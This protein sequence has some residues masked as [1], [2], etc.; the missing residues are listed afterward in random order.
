MVEQTLARSVYAI[1]ALAGTTTA[2][3]G[4]TS[5]IG[6]A[7]AHQIVAA[8]GKVIVISRSQEKVDSAKTALGESADGIA[9]DAT[10][11]EQVKATFN[12]IAEK[13]KLNHIV[14][15]SGG[16]GPS[17]A[18]L[19]QDQAGLMDIW[20]KKYWCEVLPARYA[21]PHLPKTSDSSI[22]FVTGI[23]NKKIIPG[24]GQK[25]AVNA[26]LEALAKGLAVDLKPIRVNCISPDSLT[27]EPN[28]PRAIGHTEFRTTYSDVGQSIVG[29]MLSKNTTGFTHNTDGGVTYGPQ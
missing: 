7:T 18:F 23:L 28:Q 2:I 3:V 13:H 11:E 24:V 17:G 9:M 14:L 12:S 20:M 5:G 19:E 10:N 21:T 27:E 8:G 4:G 16:A 15:S 25:V 6:L 1:T 26:A 22:T 29:L